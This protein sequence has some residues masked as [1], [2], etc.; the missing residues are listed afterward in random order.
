MSFLAGH[1]VW[2]FTI[3][4]ALMEA[5]HPPAARRPWLRPHGLVAVTV[6]CLGAAALIEVRPQHR[7][8]RRVADARRLCAA[9]QPAPDSSG[10]PGRSVPAG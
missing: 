3:P 10:V 5:M 2:S 9:T 4:I 8:P 1:V 7:V 6:L